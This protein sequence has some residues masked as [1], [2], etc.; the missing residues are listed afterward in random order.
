MMKADKAVL[1]VF[2]EVLESEPHSWRRFK[3]LFEGV[4]CPARDFLVV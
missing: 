1:A 4:Q 2:V 3:Q